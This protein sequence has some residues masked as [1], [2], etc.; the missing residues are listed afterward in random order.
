MTSRWS[1]RAASLT[2]AGG[3]RGPALRF[4]RD[5]G[6]VDV[7]FLVEGTSAPSNGAFWTGFATNRAGSWGGATNVT[8]SGGNPASVTVYDTAPAASN[9]ILR[10]RVTRP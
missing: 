9:R 3:D 8:E 7:T 2:A 4:T 10:L 6:T 5:T 1:R